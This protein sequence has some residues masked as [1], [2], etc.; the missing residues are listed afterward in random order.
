MFYFGSA[1]SNGPI[2]L[3]ARFAVPLS[4]Y[5]INCFVHIPRTGGN[6]LLSDLY[7]RRKPEG[8]LFLFGLEPECTGDDIRSVF[9]NGPGTYVLHGHGAYGV[10]R[11]IPEYKVSYFTFLREPIARTLSD[12]F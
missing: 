2:C 6:F 4:D 7:T 1:R 11:L 9:Q 12:F 10:D 8:F 3:M 5:K